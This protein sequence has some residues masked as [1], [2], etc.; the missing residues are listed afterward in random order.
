MNRGWWSLAR[1][2]VGPTCLQM[3]QYSRV[4]SVERG[5]GESSIEMIR[6]SRTVRQAGVTGACTIRDTSYRGA[7]RPA[8]R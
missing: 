1:E 8:S 6:E 2:T 5:L 7:R 3:E 4:E